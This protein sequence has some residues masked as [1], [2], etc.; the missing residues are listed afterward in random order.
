AYRPRQA[1][2]PP[3]AETLPAP[4]PPQG[5]ELVL[6]RSDQAIEPAADYRDPA[7]ELDP[8]FGGQ[9]LAGFARVGN[10][11]FVVIV[12]QPL[13]SVTAADRALLRQLAFWLVL[14]ITVG[15]AVTALLAGLRA[16]AVRR[17]RAAVD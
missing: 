1:P 3:P 10:T 13:A 7:A 9:W 11:E 2:L 14:T 15:V 6:S 12:Q 8:W 17:Q 16:R 4:P 5:R